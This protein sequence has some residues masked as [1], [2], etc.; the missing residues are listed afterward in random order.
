MRLLEYLGHLLVA[1]FEYAAVHVIVDFM[2]IKAAFEATCMQ[3]W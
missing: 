2:I 1:A 3:V